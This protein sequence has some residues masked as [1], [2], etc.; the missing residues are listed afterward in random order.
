MMD[1]A[2]SSS[3]T[4]VANSG[5]N[6]NAVGSYLIGN[7]AITYSGCF[8]IEAHFG[9]N[10]VMRW[11]VG[12]RSE[13]YTSISVCKPSFTY[14]GGANYYSN[15]Y[16]TSSYQLLLIN[17][18]TAGGL[19]EIWL[20]NCPRF[21]FGEVIIRSTFESNAVLGA[22]ISTAPGTPDTTNR[23]NVLIN[24]PIEATGTV[25]PLGHKALTYTITN[26]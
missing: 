12:F 4:K 24:S 26:A 14:Y 11:D 19:G 23:S 6:S 1:I 13:S 7:Y 9:M 2:P 18:A 25:P 15:Q 3:Y 8:T 10:C 5:I 21:S 20:L 17:P 16:T 22:V